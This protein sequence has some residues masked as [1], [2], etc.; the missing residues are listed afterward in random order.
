MGASQALHDGHHSD[1]ATHLDAAATLLEQ[2]KHPTAAAS[3]RALRSGIDGPPLNDHE[4]AFYA[5]LVDEHIQLLAREANGAAVIWPTQ[6]PQTLEELKERVAVRV[7]G[8]ALGSLGLAHQALS[9]RQIA[10]ATTHV[11]TA[12]ALLEN[13]DDP[14][15]AWLRA[16][17]GDL[18]AD[19]TDSAEQ[20]AEMVDLLDH[21]QFLVGRHAR[22][23]AAQLELNSREYGDPLLEHP[24]YP[25]YEPDPWQE[26]QHAEQ[27]AQDARADAASDAAS[28]R[29]SWASCSACWSSCHGSGS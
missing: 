25:A 11:A 12:V 17:H 23:R 4:T 16:L 1:V 9:E 28:A 14:R 15:A 27:E 8:D 2:I 5:A 10:D 7:L 13:A 6:L 18:N 3:V 21:T 20:L 22:K 19:L 29:A 24:D 26:L